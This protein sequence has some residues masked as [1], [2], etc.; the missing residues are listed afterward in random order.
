MK[1][2]IVMRNDLGMRK[3]KMVAQGAHASLKATIENMEHPSVKQWLA[4]LFTKI[5][6]RAD[7]EDELR[8]IL[9][10]ARN[11]NLITSEIIDS[12]LTEFGGT[13]TFTCIA[14]GPATDEELKPITGHLKLL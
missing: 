3:G 6:V 4:G 13:P 1:Q 7:S 11:A 2:I 5:T 12:G 10:K 9:N 14:V 8:D